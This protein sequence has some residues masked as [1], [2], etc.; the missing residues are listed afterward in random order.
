MKKKMKAPKILKAP[1][2]AVLVV[3][4]F[5]IGIIA[6][7]I[8]AIPSGSLTGSSLSMIYNWIS[9]GG[10]YEYEIP[11][12]AIT[13]TDSG[14]EITAAD[15]IR[16]LIPSS[17]PDTGWY[18]GD[19]TATIAG[20]AS[21]KVSTTVSFETT[22]GGHSNDTLVI[23]VTS[24]FAD[25]ENIVVG[26][27]SLDSSAL[28]STGTGGPPTGVADFAT[29]ELLYSVDGGLPGG[30]YSLG[31]DAYVSGDYTK[32]QFYNDSSLLLDKNN[33]YGHCDDAYPAGLGGVWT[34]ASSTCTVSSSVTVTKPLWV[35]HGVTLN[36]GGNVTL[37]TGAVA[38]NNYAVLELVGKD[39]DPSNEIVV[40]GVNI[41]GEDSVWYGVVISGSNVA[42]YIP[43]GSI[44]SPAEVNITLS[45]STISNVSKAG[46]LVTKYTDGFTLDGVTTS[47]LD[48]NGVQVNYRAENGEITNHTANS[49]GANG[50][51]VM[52]SIN[53]EITES[54]LNSNAEYGLYIHDTSL[55]LLYP[56]PLAHNFEESAA[57]PEIVSTIQTAFVN[58]NEMDSNTTADVAVDVL[59][60][61]PWT[62]AQS[63]ISIN[64]YDTLSEINGT[65]PGGQ[66]PVPPPAAPVPEFHEYVLMLTLMIALGFM[67]K[68]IPQMGSGM[69]AA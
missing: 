9:P 28:D 40:D 54:E 36:G 32:A 3:A 53:I 4:V 41:D 43:P 1:T 69:R 33:S 25:G 39:G 34:A 60:A 31:S 12:G 64:D 8:A 19:A 37:E 45:N 65:F 38:F 42:D 20:T 63:T 26:G 55:A 6:F 14:A 10:P 51:E 21:A 11:I 2:M 24:D 48:G 35:T 5:L 44:P 62:A 58:R 46:V 59:D 15:D 17:L 7:V 61:S 68:K 22:P 66:G 13:V 52:G 23:N 56:P 49:N 18:T 30:T 67:Y 47:N 29:V 57:H 27:L 50:I 16:I